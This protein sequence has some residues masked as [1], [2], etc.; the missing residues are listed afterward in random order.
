MQP[1]PLGLGAA[2]LTNPQS[3][4]LY[5]YVGN[6][7]VNFVDPIGLV[8]VEVCEADQWIPGDNGGQIIAGRCYLMDIGGGIGGTLTPPRLIDDIGGGVGG[9]QQNPPCPP[10]P[11]APPGVDISANIQTAIQHRPKGIATMYDRA[12]WFEKQVDYGGPW[13]YK[14]RDPKKYQAFGNFHYGATGAAI[15]FPENTLLRM[16][17]LAQQQHKDTMGAGDGGDPGSKS[18]IVRDWVL[19]RG[20]GAPPYGDYKNDQEEIKR[21]IQYFK[22]GC[23]R[24]N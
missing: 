13:D 18:S 23:Y 6:D 24:R 3:L 8:L 10:V 11:E 12:K 22:Q 7:P 16:A 21:G 5:S 20:G 9:N 17:G 1:D 4:N 2:N 19:G 15:G 14:T